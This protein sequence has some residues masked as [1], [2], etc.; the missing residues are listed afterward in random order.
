MNKSLD[1]LALYPFLH[2][3]L[4]TSFKAPYAPLGRAGLSLFFVGKML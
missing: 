2:G 4:K 3:I 1:E